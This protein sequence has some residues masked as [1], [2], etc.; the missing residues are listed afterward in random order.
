[1]VFYMCCHID[2]LK[3][4]KSLHPMDFLWFSNAQAKAGLIINIFQLV[5]AL[6]LPDPH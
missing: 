3:N 4:Y 1:M 5:G 2:F 6:V